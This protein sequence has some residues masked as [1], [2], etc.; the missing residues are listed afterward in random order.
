L[1]SEVESTSQHQKIEKVRIYPGADGE[2]TLYDDDGKTYA[3]EKGE[4]RIT[5]LRWDD[6]AQKLNH[7]GAQ[8]WTEPDSTIVEVVH[9]K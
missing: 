4:S 1:G 8:A 7:E 3:Y 9:Q 5:H 6:A 2:F